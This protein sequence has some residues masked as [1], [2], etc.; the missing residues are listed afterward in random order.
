M[1]PA[2]LP[3]LRLPAPRL[4]RVLSRRVLSRRARAQARPLLLALAALLAVLLAPPGAGNAAAQA[5]SSSAQADSS[6]Q[7][8]GAAERP[9]IVFIFS[10]DH[11]TQATGAYG[12]L[13]AG[14][15]PTPHLDRLAAEGMLFRRAY[16]TNSICAPSRATILSGLYSHLNGV[17][18][19]TPPD[20]LEAQV[21][22]FPE[23]LQ[24]RSDYQTAIVGKW[25]LKSAPTGF[26]HW[27]VLP[28]QGAYYNPDF[29][30]PD[31][32]ERYEGYVSQ[33]ITD[34]ALRWLEEERDPE[35][36]FMLM[37]QHKAPHRNWQP[38]PAHLDT[39][40][41]TK[42][43][44][45]RSLFYDYAGLSTPAVMQEM[46]ISTDL[47]WGMDLKLPFN[48]EHPAEDSTDA[49][50]FLGRMT[51]EQRSAFEAA[52]AP[53]NERFYQEYRSGALQERD[54]VRWKYQRYLKDYLRSVRSMDDAIGRLLAYLE[55]SGLAE[56]TVV[57]YS[58]DQGFF[59]GENGWFDKRWMYEES[60]RVPLL[61]R[62]PGVVEAGLQNSD[63]VQNL[64][65]AQTFL[66][67]AGVEAPAK[68]QGQ[69][70]VPLLRGGSAA[71]GADWRE[72]LYYR[73]YE[74]PIWHHVYPHE[75]VRTERYKLIRYYTLGQWELFDLAVD[76]GEL[77]SVYGD[78]GYA[79]VQK[80]LKRKLRQLRRQYDVP[81]PSTATDIAAPAADTASA[82]AAQGGS[83]P[84]GSR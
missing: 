60:A 35:R 44:A 5:D 1:P 33:V 15:D 21:T 52:Y 59:L 69:S 8:R 20:T 74:F 79:E 61:V 81:A 49:R 76:P 73:Y 34:R 83:T 45:P 32:T 77:E 3:N 37:Y 63:L 50:R 41:D 14:L 84:G 56:N 75:G 27:E 36:P 17:E 25:H 19:N 31:G 72:A 24:A 9:N 13:L 65:F 66:D 16:V 28:G 39:Y 43:P 46:E 54:L 55:Q 57:V 64:D 40:D 12:G 58:S 62:W 7:A 11:A 68:M 82:A 26:D 6:A 53:E 4:R 48:P 23:L 67:A 80:R 47:R 38:G 2:C 10:D 29:R 51:P 78:P 22:T 71:A 70:L 30:T 42:I 18:T